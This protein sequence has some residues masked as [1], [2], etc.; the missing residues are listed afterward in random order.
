MPVFHVKLHAA[1]LFALA[2][3]VRPALC[4]TVVLTRDFCVQAAL[5]RAEAAGRLDAQ[6]RMARTGVDLA[7]ARSVPKL[8]LKAGGRY[9]SGNNDLSPE[10]E[11]DFG[12]T[13][14]EIPQNRA[15][16]RIARSAAVMANMLDARETSVIAARGARAW[17]DFA[18][19]AGKLA[20]A[21]DRFFAAVKTADAW[22]GIGDFEGAERKRVEAQAALTREEFEVEAA[23]TEYALAAEQLFFV[24]GLDRSAAAVLEIPADY[25]PSAVGLDPCVERA[26]S[27]RGDLLA[28][29]ER[30]SMLAHASR[31]AALGRMPTPGLNFGYRGADTSDWDES[32][33]G[34]YAHAFIRIPVWDA[35]DISAQVRRAEIEREH[36]E[37]EAEALKIKVVS[38]VVAAHAAWRKAV[39]ALRTDRGPIEAEEIAARAGARLAAGDIS[40]VEHEFELLRV[41][42]LGNRRSELVL[43]CVK[44]ESDLLEAMNADRELWAGGLAAE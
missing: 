5:S 40:P 17:V 35:G 19:A 3:L 20:V 2:F 44:A 39:E 28:A 34:F 9:E 11:G 23:R 4:E 36:A 29:N 27:R 38:E 31:L 1:T 14:F 22:A 42:E 15:R 21:E 13:L 32:K 10:I 6:L 37:A 25:T 41:L 18:R 26:V 8:N 30:L 16:R 24:C 7:S 12:E 33:K 43:E